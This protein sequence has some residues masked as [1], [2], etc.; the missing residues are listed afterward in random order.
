MPIYACPI[1]EGGTARNRGGARPSSAPRG[2]APVFSEHVSGAGRKSGGAERDFIT[3]IVRTELSAVYSFSPHSFTLLPPPPSS[4]RGDA[5]VAPT[6]H[7]SSQKTRQEAQLSQR[8]R[9]AAWVS[10]GKNVRKAC[11]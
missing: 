8:D 4:P 2:D 3:Y 9:A 11:I 6:N 5:P 7:S 10:F 1:S